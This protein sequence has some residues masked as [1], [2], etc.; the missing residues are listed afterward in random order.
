MPLLLVRHASAG[1]R[2]TW[3]GDDRERPLDDRGRRDAEEL[4]EQLGSFDVQAILTSPYRALCGDGAAARASSRPRDRRA[5][6]AGRARSRASRDRTG[7]LA[8]RS[9]R[10]RVRPRR[11]R[12]D[13]VGG[14]EVEERRGVRRSARSSSCSRSSGRGAALVE[15]EQRAL[16]HPASH[17]SQRCCKKAT[18]ARSG[19]PRPLE[20]CRRGRLRCRSAARAR[21]QASRRT[22][23]VLVRGRRGRASRRRCA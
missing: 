11:P 20:G 12:L 9:G 1:D 7:P 21:R 22:A 14:A 2:T 8:R 3:E 23:R 16:A 13:R 18:A 15:L 19:S 6:G 10:G 5:R 4:V 17:H